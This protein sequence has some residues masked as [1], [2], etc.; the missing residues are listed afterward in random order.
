M[1]EDGRVGEEVGR[2]VRVELMAARMSCSFS[3]ADGCY[4]YYHAI[5]VI[6]SKATDGCQIQKPESLR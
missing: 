2:G 4:A 5:L 1:F 6:S 3:G